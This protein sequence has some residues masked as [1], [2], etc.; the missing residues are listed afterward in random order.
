M[1]GQPDPQAKDFPTL[2]LSESSDLL[3]SFGLSSSSSSF[4]SPTLPWGIAE[5]SS[6]SFSPNW[7]R[8]GPSQN[9]SG[10][11]SL[12]NV[13]PPSPGLVVRSTQEG[14]AAPSEGVLL[15]TML[16]TSMIR[17]LDIRSLMRELNSFQGQNPHCHCLCTHGHRIRHC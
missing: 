11:G 14:G 12:F 9:A 8:E 1:V 6:P 2:C 13:S 4:S 7:V 3:P 10:E 17:F 5:D 16:G 15:P